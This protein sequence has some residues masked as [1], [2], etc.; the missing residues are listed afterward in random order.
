VEI[1]SYKYTGASE[2]EIALLQNN[3]I[4]SLCLYG[5]SDIGIHYEGW[6]KFALQDFLKKYGTWDS[7]AV[8][9]LYDA[10]ID[11]PASYLKYAAGYL[12]FALLREQY[13]KKTGSADS[14]K[15]FHTFVLDVGNA[16]FSV[17]QKRLEAL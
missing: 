7:E 5:L 15:A 1:Y 11:E 13:R 2:G 17:L 3:M 9:S 14:D 10:I 12:E 6:D 4:A 8:T 16:P